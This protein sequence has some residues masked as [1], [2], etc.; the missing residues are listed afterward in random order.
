MPK[1][2][3]FELPTVQQT[4]NAYED[5]PRLAAN[6]QALTH[7]EMAVCEGTLVAVEI[8]S[9][10]RA[11]KLIGAVHIR[12]GCVKRKPD[13]EIVKA[14]IEQESKTWDCPIVIGG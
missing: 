5:M 3:S 13:P 12:T 10:A 4:L 14:Y 6:L 2:Y 9:T 7:V 1:S 11:V 8:R